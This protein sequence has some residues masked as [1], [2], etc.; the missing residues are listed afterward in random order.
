M[1]LD[2]TIDLDASEAF[3]QIDRIEAALTGAA[4]SFGVELSRSLRVLDQVAT[5]KVDAD[6]TGMAG[7][8]TAALDDADATIAVTA[9]TSGLEDATSQVGGLGDELSGAAASA[10]GLAGALGDE[11]T[12][13]AASAAGVAGSLGDEFAGAASA[14]EG[15]AG[16]LVDVG[17]ALT[18]IATVVGVREVFQFLAD[19]TTAASDLAESTSKANVV[20]GESVEA[21]DRFGR[22][23]A[24]AVG[25][26]R[27]DALEFLG[28]FGNLLTAMDL[29]QSAAAD[30]SIDIVNLG[31]DLASF[32]NLKVDDA[33]LKLRSG[34]VGEIEPLRSI[35]ISF[36]AAQVE[37]RA[38]EL[39]LADLNGVVSDGAKVQARWSLI[40]EQSAAATGDFS[41]TSTG[42]ANQQRI[43]AAEFRNVL[44]TVGQQ[45]LPVVLDLVGTA[46]G[47]LLPTL[48][49]LAVTTLP[50]LV[51]ALDALSPALGAS[52]TIV[53]A[54]TPVLGAAASVLEAIPDPVLQMVAAFALLRG[55]LGPIPNLFA[56]VA[57]R[58]STLGAGGVIS[59]VGTAIAGLVSPLGLA[60]AAF[61]AGTLVLA[62]YNQEK[63][64]SRRRV[65]EL[66]DAL[67]AEGAAVE[68]TVEAFA[69]RQLKT[70]N[71]IDDLRRLGLSV[72]E[73]TDLAGQ[74]E[75][76]L[77]K[78]LETMLRTGELRQ[79]REIPLERQLDALVRDLREGTVSAEGLNNVLGDSG[80]RST[81]RRVAEES[82][83]S[84]KAAIDNLVVT[85]ALTDAQADAAVK[86]NTLADGTVDYRGALDD[87]KVAEKAAADALA[88][89]TVRLGPAVQ[90]TEFL[91]NSQYDLQRGAD[92]VRQAMA[93]QDGSLEG[94]TGAYVR[95]G[96]RADE[97]VDLFA[98]GRVTAED[99]ALAMASYGLTV[100]EILAVQS[101][102]TEQVGAFV[103]TVVGKL[104]GLQGIVQSI[105]EEEG[106]QE[107]VRRFEIEATDLATFV[108]NIARLV[109]R[110]ADD[111]AAALAQ[112]GPT[113]ARAAREAANA[114]D[115]ELGKLEDRYTGTANHLE[116]ANRRMAD[117]A[118][119]L[120]DNWQR[121]TDQIEGVSPPDLASGIRE[122]LDQAA[123]VFE[124]E[125][126]PGGR[127][128]VQVKAL[129]SGAGQEF[130]QGFVEGI[131]VLSP[132]VG[133]AAA[134]MGKT[135]EEYAKE[136]LGIRSP[137]TVGYG[138]SQNFVLA[139]ASGFEDD[140]PVIRAAR[141]FAERVA[142]AA[143]LPEVVPAFTVATATGAAP[144]SA[145]SFAAGLGGTV[146]GRAPASV[147]VGPFIETRVDPTQIAAQVQYLFAESEIAPG[148]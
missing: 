110:G 35:G 103:D 92:A 56:T 26:A 94:L 30:L 60:S 96:P 79:V 116:A 21:I 98:R 132:A 22:T 77:R 64:E 55:A 95:F 80:L 2:E 75:E 5:V 4:R 73:F 130:A 13:A 131:G 52:L 11:V 136:I 88:S 16:S 69:E 112:A 87:L 137:S 148:A 128:T 105:G 111:L 57:A 27:Q 10:A 141:Q 84:A 99:M 70:E 124:I 3:R 50:V 40:V 139:F 23:S 145:Q 97:L 39:G 133:E 51:R 104:G 78:F 67:V 85:R 126:G 71:E 14:G 115:K 72:R 108:D 123:A 134:Q 38:L 8:V 7:E 127:F 76:G 135:A 90:A 100:E 102:V 140:D 143:T 107:F 31:A 41:R 45:L 138:L 59:G 81:F 65:Q 121:A 74:G 25:L 54:L 129:G 12:S 82:Q 89:R 86:A 142:V 33:L 109:E 144:S 48:E 91:T 18:A 24:E 53:Q 119:L 118:P 32:N 47:E 20:F 61:A 44:A 49:D 37:A 19:A 46:R 101:D 106:I 83:R 28:T 42:L 6:T 34:L 122:S 66:T 58:A 36:N 17:Q 68:E 114:S 147:Q 113:A 43:L 146:A 93:A 29:S 1:P 120:A 117:T 15:F 63:A 125:V 62:K 9:E